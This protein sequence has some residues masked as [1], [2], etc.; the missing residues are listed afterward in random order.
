MVIV[1]APDSF[2]GSLSAF[3]ACLAIEEGIKKAVPDA[4][5]I[6]VPMADG[7]EGTVQSLVDATGG[8]LI[9]TDVTGPLGERTRAFWGLMGDGETAVIEM[10]AASG[11]PLVPPD[12]RNPLITTT[13]G[14][15]ELIRAALDRGC[16][17]IIIGIGGSATNDGGAGM[18]QALGARLIDAEGLPIGFGGR[19]LARLERIDISEMERRVRDGGVEVVVACDV[20]N[21]LV[22]PRGASAVY[23]P[24]K[25]ATP[26]MVEEL[27]KALAHYAEVIERDLGKQ[28][29]DLPGA[30]A[31]GGLGAGLVAFLGAALK[32][33]V[34]IVI[35]AVGLEEHVKRADVV[36][37]GEGRM[38]FQSVY[39]KTPVGVA[40][41][42][43]RH[44]VPVIAI[45][46]GLGEGFEA[47]YD[48]GIDAV[49]S[50]VN[51][52]IGLDEAMA[53]GRNLIRD[54]GFAVAKLLQIGQNIRHKAK[55]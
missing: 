9:W 39:G 43:R 19:E 34:N 14:T 17:K 22:G 15:G 37:T 50:M 28:V 21:P 10:A 3:E 5:V 31:A 45:A 46:G 8:E 16:K 24:Q 47:V 2:K 12:K 33:G 30:G 36:I 49:L 40:A 20:D 11:L 23:G 42:A 53:N 26:E 52:P 48:H 1:V 32:P 35:D 13:Y 7:G 18:A 29:A 41:V 51:G 6:K 27:D 55:Y 38:D 25:G 44:G 54:A 4:M